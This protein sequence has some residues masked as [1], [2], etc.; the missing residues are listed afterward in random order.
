[1]KI[2]RQAKLMQTSPL[3]KLA[4]MH[5]LTQ[6]LV[7]FCLPS[8]AISVDK[9]CCHPL[10]KGEPK[11]QRLFIASVT[12]SIN[13]LKNQQFIICFHCTCSGEET[14]GRLPFQISRRTAEAMPLH[15]LCLYPT[16]TLQE[17]G[18]KR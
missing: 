12:G 1:M 17:Y 15:D 7:D 8:P 10:S 4:Q 6:L 3:F 16:S 18:I 11:M 5:R 14:A 13:S 2:S 9:H